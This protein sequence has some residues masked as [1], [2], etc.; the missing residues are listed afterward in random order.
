MAAKLRNIEPQ[1]G[2]Q[3]SFLSCPAD[4][5]IFGGAAGGGKTFALLMDPL[6]HV[7]LPGFN[8]VIFRRQSVEI[9]KPGGLWSES[10][11]IYPNTHG[12]GRE[13]LLDY[14]WPAGGRIGFSH[15]EQEGT[16]YEWQGASV[17]FIGFEELT[18]FTKSQFFYML[19]RNRSTCGVR[20]YVRATTNPD[21]DSWV[22]ELIAWWIDW[23]TGLPIY[24][25]SGVLRYFFRRGEDLI[26]GES[27]EALML[28][29]KDIDHT[30]IKSLTFIPA[31]LEDN[32]I[33]MDA[34]PGYMANLKAL[35]VVDRGRLKDGNWKI[36][37]RAGLFFKREYFEIVDA[38]PA[39]MT[40]S[41]RRWDLAATVYDG[42]NDPDYT[43]G[44][45]CY[46]NV[47]NIYYISDVA[48]D[49]LAPH[50]VKTLVKS[51]A[52]QDGI[53]VPVRL[54]Q[55]P[56]QAGKDQALQ[57]IADLSGYQVS[58]ERETGDKVTR[59]SAA[60]AQAEAGNIK[61]LRGPWNDAFITE[62]VSF[63]TEGGHDDQ[64]DA[65]SGA[66]N[67]LASP[68]EGQGYIDYYTKLAAEMQA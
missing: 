28:S 18:H 25:R 63:P 33:L 29:H 64:V 60:S 24:E 46:K 65:L 53:E 49:R 55:D 35:S 58:A 38:L 43:V 56:G 40:K 42:T 32:K 17:A 34:D 61:L 21:A 6:R 15:L 20:P 50:G 67:F 27:P 4:I 54:P 37:A 1:P 51:T 16:K 23:E 19:S 44:L 7:H 8:G 68:A 14:R 12:V 22:A 5:A 52:T 36:R 10:Q 9:R 45:K 66:I 39:G 57:Y 62:L 26:W 30:D 41:V 2:P 11:N 59:A 31:K 48:R 3:Y 47:D 13:G